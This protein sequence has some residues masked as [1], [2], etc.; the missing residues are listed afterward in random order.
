MPPA[1]GGW[2]K[3]YARQNVGRMTL[4]VCLR[5]L[6]LNVSHGSL[7]LRERWVI[8]LMRH[9]G[10]KCHIW[11][12]LRKVW[13]M[14]HL[15][16]WR[17]NFIISIAITVDSEIKLIR[18]LWLVE[19]ILVAIRVAATWVI[20]KGIERIDL[21]QGCQPL[22]RQSN[23]DWAIRACSICLRNYPCDRNWIPI[24]HEHAFVFV[25][26]WRGQIVRQLRNCRLLLSINLIKWCV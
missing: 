10:Q 24:L 11:R 9:W 6:K 22:R 26:D 5:Q 12:P 3:K 20:I 23:L 25:S 4:M 8:A 17:Y 15:T 13:L 1:S 7:G 21:S 18:S 2:D 19:A 16:E 14:L